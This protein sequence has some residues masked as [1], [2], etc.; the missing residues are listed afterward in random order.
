VR[1]Y[2]RNF[3]T[4]V[5]FTI[6]DVERYAD[7]ELLAEK[8][9]FL[10]KHI[11]CNKVFL[12]TFRGSHVI[13]R[14]T[15]WKVKQFFAG[16]GIE[17]AGAITPFAGRGWRFKSFC[18]T[19]QEHLAE[20]KKVV[21][22]T[23]EIFDEIILDDFY[24]TNCKCESC[25]KAKGD[26]TW[27]QFRIELME[28]ISRGIVVKTAKKVNPDIKMIIKYPNWYECYQNTGYN[29]EAEPEIFD[30]VYT[31]TETRNPLYTQQSLQRYTGYFLM[32][33]LENVKPGKNGGG[34]F[35]SF[36][37]L[38]N[39]G[40]YVEQAC[41]TLFAKAREVTLFCAGL[42]FTRGGIFLP[43][44]GYVFEQ[45]DGFLGKL[46]AP[47]GVRCYKPYHSSGE[48]YL[49]GYLGMLGIPLEPAPEFPVDSEL[50]FLTAGAAGDSAIVAKIKKHLLSG[51]KV[52]ITSGLVRALQ[53][54]GLE[55]IAEIKDTGNKVMVKEF[56]YPVFE[57]SFGNYYKATQEV[58]IP[59][60]EFATNDTR[61]VIVGFGAH[62][63][64]PVLLEAD[65]GGGLLYVLT[66]PENPGDLYDLPAGVLNE[67]RR[68]LTGDMGVRLEGP[69]N[70]GLFVY[71]N[72]TFIV[73][74]FLPHFADINIVVEKKTADLVDLV[75]GE[76]ISGKTA[77]DKSVFTIKME[78]TTYRVF[79]Y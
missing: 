16:R 58:L 64:F 9:G 24:F 44:A 54:K 48:N 27:P 21:E 1:R 42:L 76:K 73:E 3:S 15:I 65:Y 29:L 71:D 34:W 50:V 18:Y 8:A 70:I 5:F 79:Q 45:V 17:T 26:K 20:L 67:I 56:A 47:L 78:P 63:N 68:V 6:R 32:R 77:G 10:Q 30:L 49:H 28:E 43:P 69:A 59:H 19:N 55:D 31:G 72:N 39:L 11:R 25:I 53:N 51:K 33:Y 7:L 13:D 36:D 14:D 35:D 62:N 37:C 2:Y 41:L 52:M 75:S 46:G 61:Q 23:A 12:E 4:A 60:I 66:V 57:C 74:S 40:S 38:Y 22:F